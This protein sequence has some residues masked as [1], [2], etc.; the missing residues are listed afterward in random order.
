MSN[1]VSVLYCILRGRSGRPVS[2][3]VPQSHRRAGKYI[4]SLLGNTYVNF[5]DLLIFW[6]G[7]PY[8][9]LFWYI[10]IHVDLLN[11]SI[12][13]LGWGSIKCTNGYFFILIDLAILEKT[14]I[15]PGHFKQVESNTKYI[16]S[17]SNAASCVTFFNF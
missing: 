3:A 5:L 11:L 6:L 9:T 7:I 15:Q 8:S 10:Y 16:S 4:I 12:F 2:S 17:P 1:I 13:W 14:D